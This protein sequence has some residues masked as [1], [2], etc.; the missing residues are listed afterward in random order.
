MLQHYRYFIDRSTKLIFY[1]TDSKY[2]LNCSRCRSLQEKYTAQWQSCIFEGGTTSRWCTCLH[3][4]TPKR[5]WCGT[6]FFLFPCVLSLFSA[7]RVQGTLSSLDFFQKWLGLARKGLHRH[8]THARARGKSFHTLRSVWVVPVVQTPLS[9]TDSLHP[10][11]P[12]SATADYDVNTYFVMQKSYCLGNYV[13][14]W[15]FEDAYHCLSQ[16]FAA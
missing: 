2:L 15:C 13:N 11:T 7:P 16:R 8:C 6:A 9:N 3:A 12:S 1:L 10:L 14:T 4:H 5:I